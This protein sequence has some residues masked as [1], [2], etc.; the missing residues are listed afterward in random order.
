[1]ILES[2]DIALIIYIG[3]MVFAWFISYI[4]ASKMIKKTGLFGS[5]VFIASAINLCLDVCAIIAWSFFSW[6]VNEFIFFGGLMLGL[7]VIVVSEVILLIVL[8]VKKKQMLQAYNNN[9]KGI[10]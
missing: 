2:S 1:M 7:G 6:S 10:R 8:F 5:Q 4:F 9:A 3:F